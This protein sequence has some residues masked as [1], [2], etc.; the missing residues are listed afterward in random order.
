MSGTPA[1]PALAEGTPR[2]V[3]RAEIARLDLFKFMATS[4]VAS[5]Q[6]A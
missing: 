2:G 3:S 1:A 4:H 6:F 5:V